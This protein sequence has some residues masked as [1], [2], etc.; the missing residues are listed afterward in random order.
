MS[1]PT[2]APDLPPPG[3]ATSRNPVR[4]A[5]NTNLEK[6]R[7]EYLATDYLKIDREAPYAGSE[8]WRV[9]LRLGALMDVDYGQFVY[10]L[11]RAVEPILTAYDLRLD[12]L[13]QLDQQREGRGAVRARIA[14]L[15]YP[16]ERPPGPAA[17]GRPDGYVIDQTR[18]FA[19][20]LRDLLVCAGANVMVNPRPKEAAPISI[21]RKNGSSSWPSTSMASCWSTI[22]RSTSWNS[23]T[24]T[25]N[26]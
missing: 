22:C 10:E 14:M 15:G 23:S 1:V 7:D 16:E 26:W 3:F 24:S 12:L 17:A 9:S 19:D 20:T 13:K 6:H 8:L 21:P 11:K 18:I 25:R 2:F 4:W 5:M